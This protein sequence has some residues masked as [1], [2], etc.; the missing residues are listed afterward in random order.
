[1]CDNTPAADAGIPA[2]SRIT[3]VDGTPVKSW[4]DVRTLLVP[5]RAISQRS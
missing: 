2:N 5:H 4:F 3:S 1:V